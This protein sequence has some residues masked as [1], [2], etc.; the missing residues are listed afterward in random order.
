MVQPAASLHHMQ[1]LLQQHVL[2]PTQLQTLMKQHS[3][4]LQQSQH[5]HQVRFGKTHLVFI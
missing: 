5:Q 2:T 1:Q 3:M 4:Y